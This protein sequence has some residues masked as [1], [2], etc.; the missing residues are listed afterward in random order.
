MS[1]KDLIACQRL[2][3]ALKKGTQTFE[4]PRLP[5]D[6]GPIAVKRQRIEVG[7]FHGYSSRMSRWRL[8]CIEQMRQPEL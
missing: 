2:L 3:D 7:E 5:I 1:L 6:Q 8:K 4:D